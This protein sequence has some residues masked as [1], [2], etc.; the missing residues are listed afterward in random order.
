MRR[1]RFRVLFECILFAMLGTLMFVSKL[2]MEAL[3][4]IHLLTLLIAVYTVV[5]RAKALI[6][7]Y[8]FVLLNG[9]IAGFAPWW[10]PYLYIWTLQWATFMLVPTRLP[11][12]VRR[13]IYPALGFIHGLLFGLLYAPGQAMIF[14]LN[15]EQ[16]MLWIAQG[17]PFDVIHAVSNFIVGFLTFPLSNALRRALAKIG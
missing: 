3:P 10:I 4:N 15:A 11:I 16:T 9:I 17:F 6:P 1:K 13:W 5:F 7:I 8:I 2:I 14:G 12:K